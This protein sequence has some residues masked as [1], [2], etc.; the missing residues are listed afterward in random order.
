MNKIYSLMA[1]LVMLI[2]LASA[3][4]TI[5]GKVFDRETKEPLIGVN[6]FIPN[7]QTGVSTDSKGNFTLTSE[8]KIDTIKIS[9]IGYK[10]QTISVSGNS[11]NIALE[12]STASLNEII[13]SANREQQQR[14]EAPI[15]IHSISKLTMNETKATRLDLLLNKTPGVFMVDL[16][17]EQHSMSIRQPLGYRSLFLYLE[18]GVPIRTTGDFNHNALIEINY[19]TLNKIEIIKGPASSLYGSEAVGGAVNFITQSPSFLPTAKVQAE[20]GNFGYKRSDFFASTTVKKLG[21]FI[22]GYYADR[23]QEDSLHNDFHKL[24]LNF[25]ADYTFSEKTKLITTAAFID[26]KTDQIGGLDSIHFYNKDY[27]SF[28]RFTYRSV[29]TF[30][31]KSSLQHQWNEMSNTSLTVFY[32]N[33][34][35]GQNPFYKIKSVS[36]NPLKARGEINEDAFQS[37]GSIAQHSQKFKFLNSKLIGGVSVD[38]SPAT[39]HSNFISIDKDASGVYTNYTPSDS[40]LTQYNVDLLNTAEYLQFEINPIKRLKLVAAIRYDRLDYKFDNH[41]TP[42]AFTGAPDEKNHY[43]NLTPKIGL[44]FDFKKDRGIYINYSTGFA[45]PNITELYTGV[46]VPSL[47]PASYINYEGGGWFAFGD[48]GYFDMSIYQMDGTNEIVSV[49]LSDGS[50]EN[51]NA[52][53][54]THKGIEASI[55]YNPLEGLSIRIGGTYAEH[56]YINYIEKGIDYSGNLMNQAPLYIANSEIAYKPKFIKGFRIALEWQGMGNYFMD[57]KN[58]QKYEGFNT[59]NARMGY[60]IKGF[61]IWAN[62]I[63]LTDAIYATT[64]EK[65]SFG[66]S[67]RPGQ[68]RT[69]NLGIGYTFSKKEKQL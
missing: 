29:N 49:K 5:T 38:F 57:A 62:C 15:A 65:S 36:G 55:K 53:K 35:I 58:T 30:R 34:T 4:N 67:Y 44:T 54:T 22:G 52:G 48:K 45:P 31:A 1:F 9:F 40:V 68:L 33:S 63:N 20:L 39:Y 12:A 60:T 46:K 27:K 21:L 69:I 23:N 13:I 8:N 41:L 6:I 10:T 64:V 18:D 11:L 32:R 42:S 37:Y 51:Q 7:T 26:Y 59:F 2:N 3:Q 47:K 50:T 28:Q 66:T 16:G 43:E 17:N 14:T 56:K 19:A 61:E 24:A 25:R